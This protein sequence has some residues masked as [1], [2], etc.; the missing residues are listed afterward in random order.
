[1][2]QLGG[3]GGK[4]NYILLLHTQQSFTVENPFLVRSKRKTKAESAWSKTLD[5]KLNSCA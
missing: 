4:C 5:S 3:G 2:R 1:M